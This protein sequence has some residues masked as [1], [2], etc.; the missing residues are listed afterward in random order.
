MIIAGVSH[1]Q[2]DNE[3]RNAHQV[4]LRAGPVSVNVVVLLGGNK[5]SV[6]AIAACPRTKIARIEEVKNL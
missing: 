2:L 4:H 3:G 6:W 5:H 1:I